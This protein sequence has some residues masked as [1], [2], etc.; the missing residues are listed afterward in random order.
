MKPIKIDKLS[1]LQ[2][3]GEGLDNSFACRHPSMWRVVYGKN[4][5]GCRLCG[6][7]L[8]NGRLK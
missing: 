6:K 4:M 3:Y 2:L 1:D 7:Q 5:Q 8:P